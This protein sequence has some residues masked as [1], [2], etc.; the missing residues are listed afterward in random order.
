MEA[1]TT[2]VEASAATA[3]MSAATMSAA[4]SEGGGRCRKC[5]CQTGSS[6]RWKF[7]HDCFSISLFPV[8]YRR[9]RS[10]I[11]TVPRCRIN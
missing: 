6:D 8:S 9:R 1:A 5:S 10:R 7:C 2:A 3:A 4:E 11:S